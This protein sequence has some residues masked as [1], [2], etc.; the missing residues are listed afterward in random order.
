MEPFG[1]S[2]RVGA[3]MFHSER[4]KSFRD[5]SCCYSCWKRDSETIWW[6]GFLSGI[7]RA[8]KEFT[9]LSDLFLGWLPWY[10]EQG[11]RNSGLMDRQYIIKGT[12]GKYTPF[13]LC[14]KTGFSFIYSSFIL[15]MLVF[16]RQIKDTIWAFSKNTPHSWSPPPPP[17]PGGRGGLVEDS[18]SRLVYCFL[19][20]V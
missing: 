1:E 4:H 17:P 6:I 16:S 10:I 5:A 19:V 11:Q 18:Y 7:V 15:F 9:D 2:K 3:Y 8:S 12:I 13:F 20:I 14:K